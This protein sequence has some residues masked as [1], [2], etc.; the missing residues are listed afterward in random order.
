M[1]K[2]AIIGNSCT[3][4]TRLSQKLHEKL[5][6]ELI[7][8]DHIQYKK[9]LHFRD[10]RETIQILIALQ[11]KSSWIIDGFGPLDIL[12]PRLK[13]AD[14]IIMIDLPIYL[15]S[16]WFFKRVFIILFYG[17]RPELPEGCSERSFKHLLKLLKSIYQVH[18][19]M[20]PEMLRILSKDEFKN[21]TVL[22]T[23]LVQWEK[24]YQ[25]RFN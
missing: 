4:K 16:L 18:T 25:G 22:I 21:K 7:H 14:L 15:I 5:G 19:K 3:G 13:Q 23:D 9:G 24:I 8:I 1:N 17:K 10:Y 12:Q 2:I 11:N 6:L 20:R